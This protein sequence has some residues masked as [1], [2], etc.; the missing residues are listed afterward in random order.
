MVLKSDGALEK[1]LA[2]E[3]QNINRNTV[4]TQASIGTLIKMDNPKL[5]TKSGDE[6]KF[7]T[8]T[9]ENF[10]KAVPRLYYN[11]LK[12]PIYFYKDMRVKDSCF[13]VDD[14]AVKVL[15]HTKDLDSLYEFKDGRLW[16]SRPIAQDIAKKYPTIFQFIVF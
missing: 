14:I 5:V 15:H 2:M 13:I 6:Y 7:D 16:M 10:A 8:A 11:R 12:L 1:W 3:F 9:L 4:K